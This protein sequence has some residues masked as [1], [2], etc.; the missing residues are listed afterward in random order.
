MTADRT[1][2]YGQFKLLRGTITQLRTRLAAAEAER[3]QAREEFQAAGRLIKKAAEALQDVD[4]EEHPEGAALVLAYVD[5]S[6]WLR[7]HPEV[8]A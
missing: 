4:F 1:S 2:T 5:L 8:P 7:D 3:D 6:A